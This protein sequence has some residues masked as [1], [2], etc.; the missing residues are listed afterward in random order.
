MEMNK[1]KDK[2]KYSKIN[3]SD[4]EDELESKSFISRTLEI[5]K[6][7]LEQ[8]QKKLFP[9]EDYFD[10]A[11]R[12]N[13]DPATGLNSLQVD[14][15]VAHGLEN[16]HIK[17]LSKSIAEIIY[18]NE[19]ENKTIKDLLSLFKTRNTKVFVVMDSNGKVNGMFI[20]KN[21]TL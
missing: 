10:K 21:V 4:D 16:K 18:D 9:K 6:I 20:E 12:Y 3:I 8:S 2:E 15:R 19:L 7:I 14:E 13:P 5:P 1:G 11:I 17:K